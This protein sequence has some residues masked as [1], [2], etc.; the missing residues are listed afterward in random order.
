MHSS[1]TV[2]AQ[3]F[4]AFSLPVLDKFEKLLDLVFLAIICIDFL[5]NAV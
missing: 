4:I 3:A 5:C 2:W 1:T